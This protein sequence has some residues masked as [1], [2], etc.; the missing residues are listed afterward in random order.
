MPKLNSE[1]KL[2]FDDVEDINSIAY[3]LVLNGVEL[4]GG[5]IRIHKEE[6]Q[7]EVFKL[8]GISDEE[9]QEKFGFL[10]DA[11]KFWVLQTKRERE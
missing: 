11:L 2:E 3:D 6:I 5:S 4:G 1:G 8:L 7:K 9:A 10:L